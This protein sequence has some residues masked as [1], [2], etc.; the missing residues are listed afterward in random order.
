MFEVVWV[1]QGFRA[2]GGIVEF[3]CLFKV[4]EPSVR[5][6]RRGVVSRLGLALTFRLKF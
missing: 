2:V 6:A 1:L 3:V 4:S 5:N